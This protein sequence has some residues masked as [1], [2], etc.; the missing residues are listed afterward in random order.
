MSVCAPLTLDG[1]FV[2]ATLGFIDCQA[3]T[4]GAGGFAALAA[5]GSIV[6]LAL[7]GLLT[8]FVAGFGFRMLLGETPALRD[9][10]GAVARIAFVL[11]LA[12]A[13][14]P[15][16]TLVY[17]V[18]IA[19][20]GELAASIGG[21]AGLPGTGGDLAERLD[22]VDQALV[23]LNDLGVGRPRGAQQQMQNRQVVGSNQIVVEPAQGTANPLE[24]FAFG[25]ARILFLVG[26]VGAFGAVR[27]IAGLLL[28]LGPLFVVFALFDTTRGLFEGWVRGLVG[29]FV[30]GIAVAILLAS[31]LAL[32]EGWVADILT[33]R[34]AETPVPG[35]AIAL[36]TVTIVFGV[37]LIAGLA[38]ATR[39]ATAFR[40]PA[41]S[42]TG[43]RTA[44]PRAPQR[45]P[46]PPRASGTSDAPADPRSRAWAVAD[47]V[48]A[49]QRR[50]ATATAPDRTAS[51]GVSRA[52][53]VTAAAGGN[54][55]RGAGGGAPATATVVPLGRSF[56][57]RSRARTSTSAGRRDTRS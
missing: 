20:P 29:T 47:S 51:G 3:R 37:I 19:G 57:R 44:E 11:A 24:P 15:Y 35:A 40:L 7:T 38:A 27:L 4:L 6:S 22:L 32:I 12:T 42:G 31:E 50:E 13:W 55:G 45:L 2:S 39:V 5:P 54:G 52:A 25:L 49:T 17:D 14:A 46:V 18:A 53:I 9:G 41:W 48:A 16:R 33:Q 26:A 34:L 56:Q 1:A 23:Q 30:G 21:A 28:A 36:L 43:T 8:L 10:V